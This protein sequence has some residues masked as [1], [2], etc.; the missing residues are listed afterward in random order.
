MFYEGL[1]FTLNPTTGALTL[2]SKLDYEKISKME[3]RITT[4]NQASSTRVIIHVEDVNDCQPKFDQSV[5]IDSI[6]ESVPIGSTVL[7]LHA[8][9]DDSGLNADIRYS[10]DSEKF[11]VDSYTGVVSTAALLDFEN[12]RSYSISVTAHDRGKPSQMGMTKLVINI[13]NIND[14]FPVFTAQE[15][16]CF[17]LENK[18]AGSDVITGMKQELSDI[19]L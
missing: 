2:F 6:P 10:L 7:K 4:K 11:I 3:L 8:S 1:Y 5:Y 15:Y 14:N 19:L 16:S 9:D 18:A 12:K 13:D 17:I